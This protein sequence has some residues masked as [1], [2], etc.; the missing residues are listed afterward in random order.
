MNELEDEIL[1]LLLLK[2]DL[3]KQCVITDELFLDRTNKFIFNLFSRQFEDSKTISIVG[4][5]ENYK[6]LFNDNF[7]INE[8][9]PKLSTLM[10]EVIPVNNFN[11][12]QETLL[13]RYVQ[14]KIIS[15]VDLYKNGIVE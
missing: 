13:S 8:I 10:S 9:I 5:A 6:H 14:N 2:P 1:G 15:T 12:Y 4:L 7:K 11:Y 3:M